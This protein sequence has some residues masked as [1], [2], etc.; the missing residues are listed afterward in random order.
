MF[1]PWIETL[2]SGVRAVAS[3]IDAAIYARDVEMD[4]VAGR[5]GTLIV[6]DTGA[7]ST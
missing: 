4:F 1:L 3:E 2:M 6:T 5:R 7:S